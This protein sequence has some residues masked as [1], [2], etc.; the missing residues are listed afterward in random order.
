MFPLKHL[1][2][3]S[4]QFATR[5]LRLVKCSGYPTAA[6]PAPFYLI[7]STLLLRNASREAPFNMPFCKRARSMSW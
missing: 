5:M 3:I 6:F 7:M 1:A 2:H 4:K